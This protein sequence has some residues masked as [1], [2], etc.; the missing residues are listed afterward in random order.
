MKKTYSKPVLVAKGN[1]S[2]VTAASQV[3]PALQPLIDFVFSA[4]GVDAIDMPQKLGSALD[5]ED[6][7]EA[8]SGRERQTISRHRARV[9]AAIHAQLRF[10]IQRRLGVRC[11]RYVDRE[12]GVS[13]FQMKKTYSK[14]VLVAKGRLSAVTAQEFSPPINPQ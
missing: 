8:G 13:R 5:E 9:F 3:S 2:A 11:N 12:S 10:R 1:L 7:L 4:V 14:P 6:L